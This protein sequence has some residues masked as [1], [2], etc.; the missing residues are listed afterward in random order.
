M[1]LGECSRGSG[2]GMDPWKELHQGC[3]G[4]PLGK[5]RRE[6]TSG[7]MIPGEGEGIRNKQLHLLR[8][9]KALQ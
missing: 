5:G 1:S 4:E 8:R 6:Q 9:Y 7:N 3:A 2:L